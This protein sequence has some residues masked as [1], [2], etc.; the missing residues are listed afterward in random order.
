M[1]SITGDSAAERFQAEFDRPKQRGNFSPGNSP[2]HPG[3]GSCASSGAYHQ[4]MSLAGR[5]FRPFQ[6]PP[7]RIW[8]SPAWASM[9]A[10]LSSIRAA[11]RRP[12]PAVHFHN[13]ESLDI[14]EGSLLPWFAEHLLANDPPNKASSQFL[15]LTTAPAAAPHSS[16]AHMFGAVIKHFGA[17]HSSFIGAVEADGGWALEVDRAYQTLAEAVSRDQ[18]LILLG[19]A[20]N[21]VHLTDHL[22]QSGRSFALPN[23]L[24]GVGNRR[25]QRPLTGDPKKRN[26]IRSLARRWGSPGTGLSVNT[27]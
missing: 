11:R 4:R 20:F 15:C 13:R 6:P 26:Y 16:L 21:Y 3:T 23:W 7:S 14:Y 17:G 19:T 2:R 18:P 24:E 27:E 5:I 12:A 10:S 25:L 22:R 1:A 9:I 8:N